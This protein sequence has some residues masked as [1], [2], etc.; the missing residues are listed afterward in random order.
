MKNTDLLLIYDDH[1]PLCSWYSGQFVK[2]GLLQ[3]ENR[4]P[5]SKVAEHWLQQIDFDASRNR[6]PLIDKKT[7]TVTYGL[8]ALLVL[9]GQRFPWIQRVGHWKPVHAFLEQLYA[10]I[11]YNRKVVVAVKCGNGEIDCAPDFHLGY[12]ITFLLLLQVLIGGAT[13]ASS[14]LLDK[15]Q[16]FS[17]SANVLQYGVIA[18]AV[19]LLVRG[20]LLPLEKRME[21]Y[22]QW[23]MLGMLYSVQ[24]VV[25]LVLVN[26]LGA[27]VF[28]LGAGSS[29]ILLRW[30]K[31]WK[32]RMA[33][34]GV[35]PCVSMG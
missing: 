13:T 34:T 17:H 23:S 6:I 35:K 12:R 1:C 3:K 10:L 31:S 25:L 14:L 32:R 7:G 24:L 15:L 19:L 2:Y 30:Y 9:L 33:F 20:F 8:D 28:L 21:Y 29:L 4:Q 18:I 11:S 26:L 5:F 27:S 22:G 16:L